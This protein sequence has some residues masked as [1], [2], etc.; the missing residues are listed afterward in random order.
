MLRVFHFAED[1]LYDDQLHMGGFLSDPFHNRG[2]L[3]NFQ[4]QNLWKVCFNLQSIIKEQTTKER[5]RMIHQ[6][7]LSIR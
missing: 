2:E 3:T 4:G 5:S 6:F 1:A 7:L